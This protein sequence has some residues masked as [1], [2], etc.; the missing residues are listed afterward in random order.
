MIARVFFFSQHLFVAVFVAVSLRVC[1]CVPLCF[2]F[3]WECVCVCLFACVGGAY[4][5]RDLLDAYISDIRALVRVCVVRAHLC[6]CVCVCVCACLH[7]R[8]SVCLVVCA[9]VCAR[10]PVHLRALSCARTHSQSK[11]VGC[12]IV[13]F[14][15]SYRR[16]THQK[17]KNHTGI[18]SHR[19]CT[20]FVLLFAILL[21]LSTSQRFSPFF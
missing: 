2:P 14:K 20:K 1:L 6:M 8:V 9:C 4:M 17:K 19:L 21:G 11:K 7:A 3:P 16:Y 15:S 18:L 10:V 5:V 13:S 12:M